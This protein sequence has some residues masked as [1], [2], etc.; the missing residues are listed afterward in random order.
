MLLIAAVLAEYPVD[1]YGGGSTLAYVGPAD[2]VV[3]TR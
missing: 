3:Y 1:G 2:H